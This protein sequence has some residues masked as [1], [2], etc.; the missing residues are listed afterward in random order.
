MNSLTNISVIGLFFFPA[1]R[2]SGVKP[3]KSLKPKK[4][5][6]A[7]NKVLLYQSLYILFEKN[8]KLFK[9]NV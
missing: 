5:K 6:T 2:L 3:S 4:F 1:A 7:Y 8:I 9:S